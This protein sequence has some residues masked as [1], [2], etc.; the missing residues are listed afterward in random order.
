MGRPPKPT[1]TTNCKHCQKVF[2]YKRY[3]TGRKWHYDRTQAF[4]SKQCAN[5]FQ[6]KGW[7]TDK[8]G[9]KV[10]YRSDGSK[11]VWVTQHRKVMEESL[12]RKLF[13]HET[14]HHKDGNRAN[15]HISNLELWS[16]RHGKGQRVEDKIDFCISFLKEYPELLKDA[17][18]KIATPEPE[19]AAADPPRLNMWCM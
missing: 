19:E 12:G 15:N 10:S 18:Y 4:C 14:I 3:G 6:T 1:P 13:S 8:H 16:S 17:G 2:A 7:G 5:D 9:Y 11:R